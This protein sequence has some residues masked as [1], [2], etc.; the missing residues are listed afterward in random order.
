M[1]ARTWDT[2]YSEFALTQNRSVDVVSAIP[3]RGRKLVIAHA[4]G[5]AVSDSAGLIPWLESFSLYQTIEE[6]RDF[7]S[8][9]NSFPSKETVY[10]LRIRSCI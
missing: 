7:K 3:A 9:P 5:P 8:F 10:A 2:N 6:R 1:D 4:L